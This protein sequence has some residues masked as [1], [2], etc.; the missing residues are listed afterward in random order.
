MGAHYYSDVTKGVPPRSAGH[1]VRAGHLGAR[2]D[3]LIACYK[4]LKEPVRR[5]ALL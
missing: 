3:A 2:W 1:S 4:N 5:A